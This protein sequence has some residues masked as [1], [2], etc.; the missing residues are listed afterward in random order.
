MFT[1]PTTAFVQATMDEKL[2][3]AEQ[4]RTA[5]ALRR[6]AAAAAKVEGTSRGRTPRRHPVLWSL[7]HLRH[8]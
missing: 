3:R 4:V 6:E 5:R 1:D 2:R 7:T 8:A